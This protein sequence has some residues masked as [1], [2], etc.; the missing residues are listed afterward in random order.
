M[1]VSWADRLVVEL[2]PGAIVITRL[3]VNLSDLRL[4]RLGA[5]PEKAEV[6]STVERATVAKDCMKLVNVA[7]ITT[8]KLC[9]RVVF[10]LLQL[11]LLLRVGKS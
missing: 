7:S 11:L 8:T 9:A 5:D 6:V 2:Y 3:R 4:D 10:F 1:L